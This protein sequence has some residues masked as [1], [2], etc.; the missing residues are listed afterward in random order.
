MQAVLFACRR[1]V[2]LPVLDRP[3][4]RHAVDALATRGVREVQLVLGEAADEIEACLGDGGR[5]GCSFFVHL[6]RD[7]G[8]PYRVL[9]AIAAGD[10]HRPV[11]VA[12][13]D[14]LPC[15]TL[16]DSGLWD[17]PGGDWSGW[18]IVPAGLLRAAPPAADRAG[19]GRFLAGQGAKR[20]DLSGEPIRLGRPTDVLTANR[21]ALAGE[22][23]GWMSGA[24]ER[25]TGIRVGPCVKISPGATLAAPAF[26]GENTTVRSGAIVGP[27]A[28]IGADCLIDEGAIV[29]DAVVL[30]GSY[31]GMG[32]AVEGIVVDRNHVVNPHRDRPE[33]VDGIFLGST[34]PS[35][36]LASLG[37]AL[38]RLMA[39]ITFVAGLPV[40]L[41]AAVWLGLFRAGPLVTRRELVRTPASSEPARW[42]TFR[43]RTLVPPRPDESRTG[44]VIPATPRGVLLEFLPALLNV[45]LGDLRLTGLPPRSAES[46]AALPEIRQAGYLRTPA[47][48]IS[49]SA[50]LFPGVPADEEVLLADAFQAHADSTRERVLRFG[51]FLAKASCR[52]RKKQPGG[53]TPDHRAMTTR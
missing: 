13:A 5:W 8:R 40:L 38:V 46:L 24:R 7:P 19:L 6:A 26:V 1:S 49:E 4:V 35:S 21:R 32:V 52:S 36:P 25:S 42:R 34:T 28:V 33:S 23:P 16:P 48:L 10:P 53:P 27:N 3:G 22:C 31:V 50:L 30:P 39:A 15:E 9:R 41:A 37:A 43:V 2:L 18:G 20:V 29:R 12:H 44:W 45:A 14:T 47:G 11:L 17:A 51:R